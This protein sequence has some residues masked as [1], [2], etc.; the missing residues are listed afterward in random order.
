MPQGIPRQENEHAGIQHSHEGMPNTWPT[1]TQEHPPIA[2]LT[3]PPHCDMTWNTW[4]ALGNSQQAHPLHGSFHSFL[5]HGCG[6]LSP[7]G[8]P[9][10]LVS[11]VGPWSWVWPHQPLH[12]SSPCEPKVATSHASRLW[13]VLVPCLHL[14]IK[15]E[16]SRCPQGQPT[17]LPPF[18]IFKRSKVKC[19]CMPWEAVVHPFKH[20]TVFHNIIG[21]L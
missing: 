16:P 21:M 4:Q 11:L 7:L 8:A 15:F 13:C 10:W 17:L 6:W 5:A 2:C 9:L 1:C 18:L 3:G 19:H 14:P 20:P 12:T